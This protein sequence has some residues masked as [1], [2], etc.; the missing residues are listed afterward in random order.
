MG[1]K[2]EKEVPWDKRFMELVDYKGKHGNCNVPCG[3]ADNPRLAKWVMRQRQRHKMNQMTDEHRRRLD[4]LHFEFRLVERKAPAGPTTPWEERLRQLIDYKAMTGHLQVKAKENAPLANW[5]SVQRHSWKKNA[6]SDE[7]KAQLA[8]IGFSPDAGRAPPAKVEWDDRFEQLKAYKAQH[9]TFNVPVDGGDAD[10]ETCQ[11]GYWVRNQRMQRNHGKMREDRIQKM[12]S[13]GFPWR[14]RAGRKVPTEPNELEPAEAW[15]DKLAKLAVYKQLHGTCNVPRTVEGEDRK[16]SH[17]VGLQRQ[18]K[19]ANKMSQYEQDELEKLGFEWVLLSKAER[20]GWEQQ[21]EQLVQFKN[22]HGHCKVPA[23]WAE[24][25]KLAK[26]VSK[27]REKQRMNKLPVDRKAKL[28]SVQFAWSYI[29]ASNKQPWEARLEQLKQ[30]KATHGHC[31]VPK[32]KLVETEDDHL[33][34]WLKFQKWR[35]K[36][37]KMTAERAAELK[38]LGVEMKQDAVDDDDDDDETGDAGGGEGSAAGAKRKAPAK[39]PAQRKDKRPKILEFVA[40]ER[41]MGTG[42]AIFTSTAAA[43]PHY[44]VDGQDLPWASFQVC[45]SLEAAKTWLVAQIPTMNHKEIP[46]YNNSLVQAG[47]SAK[48]A[49]ARRA[50]LPKPVQPAPVDTPMLEAA[51]PPAPQPVPVGALE[52]PPDLSQVVV[53]DAHLAL[54]HVASIP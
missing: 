20:P 29:E 32:P 11:L 39:S 37:N 35:Y 2:G 6:L 48:R 1:A 47:P 23:K 33:G 41:G 18:R 13:I 42:P 17:W 9:N 4:A 3:W 36:T 44:S 7:R 22:E 53:V 28:D 14:L 16:L 51:A 49:P 40:V 46:V 43:R 30:Y 52:P 12:D 34:R 26:W 21:F 15:K 45:H 24:N 31:N 8:A 10:K 27:Q 19:A 50:P 38:A 25:P 5:L 54:D